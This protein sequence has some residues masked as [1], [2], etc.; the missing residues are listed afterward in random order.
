[1]SA[2]QNCQYHT[3]AHWAH[4]LNTLWWTQL[5]CAL[6]SDQLTRGHIRMGTAPESTAQPLTALTTNYSLHP[7]CMHM[8]AQCSRSHDHT[9]GWAESGGGLWGD[10]QVML[11]TPLTHCRVVAT[12]GEET[13]SLPLLSEDHA[14]QS[15]HPIATGM[16]VCVCCVCGPLVPVSLLQLTG[17]W[18]SGAD[19]NPSYSLSECD[20]R[21]LYTFM[22]HCGWGTSWA[23]PPDALITCCKT[24]FITRV[25]C[26]PRLEEVG[27]RG[28]CIGGGGREGTGE[29]ESG[30]ERREQIQ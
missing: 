23:G 24:I 1:M 28:Q 4:S 21:V 18:Q 29:G 5:E 30:R 8:A 14:H 2:W 19:P 26:C 16:C 10:L 27:G 22:V 3:D 17:L 9:V 25:P 12:R 7:A 20:P 11:P 6:H 15:G 13:T